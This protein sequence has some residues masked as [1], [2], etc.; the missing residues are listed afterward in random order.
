MGGVNGIGADEL[1]GDGTGSGDPGAS[2]DGSSAGGLEPVERGNGWCDP[3]GLGPWARI[4]VGGY[5]PSASGW[6]FRGWETAVLDESQGSGSRATSGSSRSAG[7]GGAERQLYAV[8]HVV[9][10]RVEHAVAWSVAVPRVD[11]ESACGV[12]ATVADVFGARLIWTPGPV[13]CDGCAAIVTGRER[14]RGAR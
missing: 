6:R 2:G 11:A 12:E 14:P 1:S 7:G 10:S 5:F 4:S 8:A 9:P 3:Y 13:M